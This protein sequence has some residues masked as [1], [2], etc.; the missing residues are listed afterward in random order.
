MKHTPYSTSINDAL[1]LTGTGTRHVIFD[2]ETQ[3]KP[4]DELK[5]QMPAFDPANVKHGN[6]KDPALIAAKT[7]QARA[8]HESNYLADAALCPTTGR[9]AAIGMVITQGGNTVAMLALDDGTPEWEVVA[10]ELFWQHYITTWNSHRTLWIGHNI[11][12]FD[13]PL[14][15]NRSRI[16][17][18]TLPATVFNLK[19][20]KVYFSDKF[21]D[22]RTL[23]LMGRKATDVVS[24]LDHVSK[25][26]GLPGKNGNGAEF[27]QMLKDN[28]KQ[29]E[30][31][32]LSDLTL[33]AAVAEKLGA[34]EI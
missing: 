26:F 15:V 10:L 1:A 14:L 2:I 16:L 29:A 34:I 18:I 28:P 19:G 22:T 7:E 31:Y 17:G 33:T 12:D 11:L 4:F 27:G 3:A 20:N 13:L 32:L 25:A 6:T 8:K 21:I 23:W 24:N 9:L 30:A 5:A